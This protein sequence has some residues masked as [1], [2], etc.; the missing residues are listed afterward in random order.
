MTENRQVDSAALITPIGHNA[1]KNNEKFGYY[2]Y[3]LF[4]SESV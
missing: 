3:L 1:Q 4:C 2:A